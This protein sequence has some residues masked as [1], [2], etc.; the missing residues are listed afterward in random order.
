MCAYSITSI[1]TRVDL[2]LRRLRVVIT[3]AANTVA[4][5]SVGCVWMIGSAIILLLEV[6]S[7]MYIP[8]LNTIGVVLTLTFL[9]FIA[10][11]D[12]TLN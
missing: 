9:C 4:M 12:M 11:T 10:A 2:R 5:T 7:S 8:F 1:T 6:I 3:C